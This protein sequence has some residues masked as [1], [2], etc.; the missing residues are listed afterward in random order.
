MKKIINILLS[1]TTAI[2]LA[3][4]PVALYAQVES[5][6]RVSTSSVGVEDGE[7]RQAVVSSDGMFIAFASGATN[8]V[9]DDTNGGEDVFVYNHNTETIERVSINSDEE[10]TLPDTEDETDSS[11]PSISADGRYVAFVSKGVNLVP[12]D[13]NDVIDVFV[14]DRDLGTTERVS[15]ATG[16]TQANASSN[17]AVISPDGRYVAFISSA[18]NLVGSDTNGVSDVFVHDR[19]TDTTERVSVSSAETQADGASSNMI[20]GAFSLDNRYLT[21]SS[22]ASNL[23]AGDS[24]SLDDVF[25]RDLVAGTTERVSLSSEGEEIDNSVSAASISGDGRYVTFTSAS[26]VLIE[27]DTNDSEDVYVYD[28]QTD[29]IERVS[30]SSSGDEGNG[31]SVYSTLSNDGRYVSFSSTATNLVSGDTNGFADIFL[32]DR[33]L[34]ITERISMTALEQQGDNDSYSTPTIVTS[35]GRYAVFSSTA[36]NFVVDDDNDLGDSFLVKI[37]DNDNIASSEEDAAPNGGDADDSGYDDAIE[38]NITSFENTLSGEYMSVITDGTCTDNREL[39]FIEETGLA[40]QD[41]GY[42]YPLGIVDFSIRCLT[43]SGGTADVSIYFFGDVDVTNLALRKVGD[44]GISTE[45]SGAVITETTLGGEPAVRVSYSVE[46]GGEL[47]EDGAENGV[48]VDPV[49]LAL[50]TGTGDSGGSSSSGSRPSRRVAVNNMTP[51]A[52]PVTE[53]CHNFVANMK[54]GSRYGEVMNLQQKLNS[55][56][57]DSGVADGW[58]GS[59]TLAAVKKFQAANSLVSDGIVGPLTRAKL[60]TCN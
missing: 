53:V 11:E 26:T 48:I 51:V 22:S 35:N 49:G 2:L 36:T 19:N 29:V 12:S 16:G 37:T 54:F 15:I 45:I 10:E 52:L 17:S 47:D 13:T 6:T 14:R 41:S 42:D 59:L 44:D 57:F 40:A 1:S 9:V 18:T 7:S 21:F 38:R 8:L 20:N 39:E 4:Q 31:N 3:F 23:V 30:I 32:H 33:D 60:N 24:N 43:S 27:G 50:S 25:V 5:I 55:S 28:R 46:D 56:G 34:G 58:F